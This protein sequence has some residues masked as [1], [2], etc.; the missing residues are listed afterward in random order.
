MVMN[1]FKKWTQLIFKQLTRPS[2][3]LDIKNG[4]SLARMGER[5]HA[6]VKVTK[7]QVK[8]WSPDSPSNSLSTIAVDWFGMLKLVWKTTGFSGQP[9]MV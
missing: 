2:K 9:D 8:L 1:I 3:R 4:D 7:P 6:W 5:S